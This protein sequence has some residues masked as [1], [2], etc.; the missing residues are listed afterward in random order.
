MIVIVKARIGSPSLTRQLHYHSQL[1]KSAAR[2]WKSN[3]DTLALV[4]VSEAFVGAESRA[5]R[6]LSG[7]KLPVCENSA[8]QHLK[9]WDG[10]QTETATAPQR[11]FFLLSGGREST[12]TGRPGNTLTCPLAAT[13]STDC[14]TCQRT[15]PPLSLPSPSLG[16]CD[17]TCLERLNLLTFMN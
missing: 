10:C 16:F 1:D 14:M 2:W 7:Q 5:R 8:N 6:V 11:V 3:E 9:L 15:F 4:T 17:C 12:M 13:H